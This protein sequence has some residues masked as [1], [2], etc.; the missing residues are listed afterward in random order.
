MGY[1]TETQEIPES[2]KNVYL[3]KIAVTCIVST[4]TAKTGKNSNHATPTVEQLS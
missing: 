1:K 2:T 4:L 3:R